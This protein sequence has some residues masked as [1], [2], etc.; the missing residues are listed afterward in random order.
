MFPSSALNQW[1]RKRKA[2]RRLAPIGLFLASCTAVSCV[3]RYPDSVTTGTTIADA[4]R[5]NMPSRWYMDWPDPADWTAKWSLWKQPDTFPVPGLEWPRDGLGEPNVTARSVWSNTPQG[6]YIL[7]MAIFLALQDEAGKPFAAPANLLRFG[8]VYP[9]GYNEGEFL[10]SSTYSFAG[11]PMGMVRERD[12]RSVSAFRGAEAMGVSCAACHTGELIAPDA[13]G[14]LTRFVVDGGQPLLDFTDFLDAL[15]SNLRRTVSD[16]GQLRALCSRAAAVEEALLK[17]ETPLYKNL[18]NCMQHAN[19]STERLEARLKRNKLAVEDGPGRLDALAQLLNELAVTHLGLPLDSAHPATAPV[20]LPHVWSAPDLECVQTNCLTSDPLS[21]NLGEVSGVFGQLLVGES[22]ETEG[23]LENLGFNQGLA[24]LLG[25]MRNAVSP[26]QLAP[27]IRYTANPVNM[28]LLEDALKTLP[29]P[30]WEEHFPLDPLLKEG[31]RKI[32]HE[33]VYSVN[34]SDQTCSS[35]H[36]LADLNNP[37]SRAPAEMSTDPEQTFFLKATRW[38]PDVTQTDPAALDQLGAWT[39]P[40]ARLPLSVK[41]AFAALALDRKLK[42]SHKSSAKSE[43]R[44]EELLMREVPEFPGQEVFR[45]LE[46]AGS[47]FNK[48]INIPGLA[49]FGILNKFAIDT[50]AAEAQVSPAG[51]RFLRHQHASIKPLD[52]RVYKARPLNGVA[53]TAPYLHN[54]SVP[55]LDDLFTPEGHRPASFNVGNLAYDLERAGYLPGV[56]AGSDRRGTSFRFDTQISGNGNKGHPW[57]TDLT[58]TQRQALI[59]YLKSL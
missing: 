41:A 17:P 5:L 36:V 48:L 4:S 10:E 16:Q 33:R 11:L 54:G 2:A 56:P 20:S 39:F 53:F 28:F 8:F 12:T 15:T 9:P 29:A 57:G 52:V 3:S 13:Q 50:W 23:F 1:L 35:C 24:Q 59:T 19:R 18:D 22:A 21:R 58:L 30:R 46:E 6:S 7:P 49:V 38:S 55:T 37:A 26:R 42:A 40:E 31:G 43:N 45:K 47:E 27:R 32:Y 14:V 34:G 25:Q 44:A 51:L